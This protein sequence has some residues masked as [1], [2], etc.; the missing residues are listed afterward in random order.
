MKKLLL[1]FSFML[2][3]TVYGF[4]QGVTTASF[5]GT[6]KDQKGVIPGAT[7]TAIHIPS[8]TKY[9]TITRADGRYNLPNVRV[10]GPYIVK[11]S[12]IGYNELVKENLN[13]TIGEDLRVDA[14]LT[15][16]S[17]NLADVVVKGTQDKVINS[18]RTGA[19][20]TITRQQIDNLP[21]ISR[22]LSDFTKL[23]PSANS[24]TVGGLSFGGRSG[25]YNNLTVDGAL[26]NNSFGLSGSLGG[27]ANSQPI[28]LDAIE[29][30]QVDI[31]PYDVRQG[32]FTGA[33][34]NTIVKSGTNDFKGS[35]YYYTRGTDLTGYS[36]GVTKIPVV[37]FK[38]NQRGLNIGGPII[39]D[40]LFFFVSG[41]QERISTP[42][43]SFV[44]SKPGLSGAN[45]SAADAATLD[46]LSNYLM[47]KYNY[48]TGPYENYPYETKSDKITAKI[49]WNINASN[50]LSAKYFYLKSN[51][52]VVA[53]GSGIPAGLNG[54][55]SPSSTSMPY[56]GSSYT[57][58]NNFNI[59]IVELN[60]RIGNSMSNKLTLGYSALRDFRASNG[61]ELPMV[62]IGNGN[63]GILTSFGYEVF[64]ANN[65]LNSDIYQFSDDFSIYAGKHEITIGT[66]NQLNKFLNGF[67]PNYNGLYYFRTADDFMNNA[68]AVSYSYRNSALADGAFPFAKMSSYNLSL[69]AQ[70]KYQV[71]DNF[72]LTYGI[73]ADYTY[74]P[75]KL[76]P[77]PNLAALTFQ[78]GLQ[79]DISKF[80]NKKLL[81]SP[82]VGFNYDVFGDKT[83]QLR[84]GTGIFTGQVPY[85]WISNQASNTGTLFSSSTVSTPG[86]PRLIFNPNV[87]AN[88]P[89]PG[90]VNANT[91]YEVD[92]TSKDFKYPQIWRTN[93]AVDQKLPLGII[94]TIEASYTKD[95]NA[96]NF[97]N[98][99]LPN[100][101]TGLITLP[102]I[103]G[104][105][106]YTV[107]STQT[108]TTA[109]NPSISP[110]I[111]MQN[112]KKGYSYFIT[113][114]LQKSFLNGFNASAA[115]TYS[116][117]RSV[118]DGGSTASSIWSQRAIAGDANSDV[119]ANT[120]FIQPNRVIAS[121]SYKREYFKHAATT[122]GLIF[123]SANNGAFSYVSSGDINND[124]GANDLLYIPQNQ[125]DITLVPD[126]VG[127]TRTP[128]QIWNQLNA[129]ISQDSYLSKHR[130]EFAKRNGAIMSYFKR[131]DLHI[132]QDFFVGPKGK[133]NTLQ[134]TL[135]IINLGNMLN[136]DWGLYQT[137]NIPLSTYNTAVLLAYK[138]LDAVSGKATYSFPYQDKANLTPY[139]TTYKNITD[140]IS[141]WQAQ[142]GVRYIFN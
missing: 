49:D 35:A 55:R 8:G 13:T 82:R 130:G 140:Q 89:A 51:R 39:K 68:P 78:N 52:Q 90:T 7:V 17:Q 116:Q 121:L 98:A 11:I 42:A 84:G 95:I 131:A 122:I 41:E 34:I 103:E 114:Q 56:F 83:T 67:A 32:S 123:E 133:R 105:Q 28:S 76:D 100:N 104:Q 65:L 54:S 22:S 81:F 88:R 27:Q 127:D 75:T 19:R 79:V 125:G 111:Y 71:S 74:F 77:N 60:T 113:G 38:Y 129:Y 12:Y 110:F 128:A 73:R 93:V 102:G 62:D 2:V 36:A 48:A 99:A 63:G 43:T 53:S 112:T 132:A 118:N 66:S 69:Y 25:S 135:D 142:F 45:V 21:T 18:S 1:L 124:G 9:A 6:V 97:S 117:S 92:A 23:T 87:N 58:N 10:G 137:P 101:S 57:I 61:A 107:K 20:E 115:Y 85:V 126:F 5:I 139:T 86:D 120:N 16:T 59:G 30:I 72:K 80:P 94:A 4:A 29:Q 3:V 50:T 109:A 24:T 40:K 33:G 70:D 106:R 119:L 37:D 15:E 47:S 64:T 96:V 14:S 44:A 134:F 108:G 26:F 31:A 136:S 141:R 138:G 46:K 91:S